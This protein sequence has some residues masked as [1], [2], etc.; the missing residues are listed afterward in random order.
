[1]I[2]LILAIWSLIPLPFLHPSCTSGSSWFTYYWS[3]PWRILSISLV[4]CE[5]SVILWFWLNI[6]CSWVEQRLFQFS[7]HCWVFQICW[8]IECSTSTASLF[9]IW[10]SSAGIPSP[11]LALFIVMLPNAHLTSHSR[12]SGSRWM[13]T[14]SL[15]WLWTSFLYSSSVYSFHLFLIY[16][17]LLGLYHLCPLLCHLCMKCS[18]GISN[19]LEEIYSL[20]HSIVF[21]YFFALITEESFL[22]SSC[23]SLELWI[24]M[25]ISFLFSFVLCISSF[26]A[27]FKPSSD[28][29][30]AILHFFLG[31]W[32]WSLPHVQCHYHLSFVLQALYQI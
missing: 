11:P 8:H 5:M 10:N 9:R 30:F 23:Y 14:P 1:M 3:L 25:N 2:Q 29:H 6:L 31:G 22:N 32:S 24:Q 19:F 28:S 4:A 15:S 26:S 7:G 20:S 17:A 21:L 16:S 13:I 27:T 12:M 18:L